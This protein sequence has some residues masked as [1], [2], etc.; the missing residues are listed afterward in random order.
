MRR[1]LALLLLMIFS[2]GCALI[3]PTP[4][5]FAYYPSPRE[6]RTIKISH[7]LYRAAAPARDDPPRYTSALIR[8]RAAPGAG[9]GLARGCRG[10]PS[11]RPV[12]RTTPPG[13]GTR[14]RRPPRRARAARGRPQGHHARARAAAA[15]RHHGL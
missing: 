14:A 10:E 3:P 6:P 1:S 13:D 12:L 11:R 8:P 5:D 9:G 4:P 15:G 7:A 2:T